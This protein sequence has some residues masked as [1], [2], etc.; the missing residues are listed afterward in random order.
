MT[1]RLQLS[2]SGLNSLHGC[3]RKWELNK[4]YQH[5]AR[6][7]ESIAISAG[8]VLHAAG[9]DYMIYGDVDRALWLL[10]TQ[11]PH[12]FVWESEDDRSWEACMSTLIAMT[13]HEALRNLKLAEI[14]CPDGVIRQAIEVP[15]E[16]V[17][18]GVVLPDGRGV[19][20]IGYIDAIMQ[21]KLT[22]IYRTLDIKTHRAY[23]RDRTA[24][25]KFDS[26]QLPYG[27]A[28]EHLLGH[29]IEAFEVLYLDCFVDLLDPRVVEY[30]FTKTPTDVDEWLMNKVL[31]LRTLIQYMKM[32]IFPRT[33]GG[34][35][36]YNKPCKYL[37]VCATRDRDTLQQ[38][39]LMNEEPAPPR[40]F[41]P[42]ISGIIP[43]PEG[44]IT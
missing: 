28:L 39:L 15:F 34:C 20:F 1:E 31:Q 7:F 25:Y 5:P 35:I 4:L 38:F 6:K 44:L 10:A 37:D 12:R 32:G 14:K 17:F 36:A 23:M 29:E 30:K 22:G 3:A 27:L 33:D 21:S 26:Q 16:L 40:E 41:T 24:A 43:I 19:S 11:Y 9:Q 13:E 18:D 8:H 2:Y 42:W